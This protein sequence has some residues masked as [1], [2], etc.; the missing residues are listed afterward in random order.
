MYQGCQ[1]PLT[2][3]CPAHGEF[4]QRPDRHLAGRGCPTC[5]RLKQ[6]AT[7]NGLSLEVLLQAQR[8]GLRYCRNHGFQGLDKFYSTVVRNGRV[9]YHCL[10][11][12]RGSRRKNRLKV[13]RWANEYTQR[14]RLEVLKHYSPELECAICGEGH[15]EFLA[16]DHIHGGGQ[17]K[18]VV[19]GLTGGGS[20][21][22]SI[23]KAG[24]PSG[25]RVLCHNC[26][27]KHGCRDFYWRGGNPKPAEKLSTN[28]LTQ[29]VRR[30]NARHPERAREMALTSR[31]K[32][33][34][35][36]IGHY[37]GVCACCGEDDL[38]VLSI[39]HVNGGGAR[40][41]RELKAKGEVFGY[42]WLKKNG[43][44]LGFRVLCLNCNL[45][46]GLYGRCPHEAV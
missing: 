2:I 7:R 27:H 16:L 17:G 23:R 43:F 42:H 38:D 28:P 14:I 8:D 26:N 30:F 34:A 39:D 12:S 10:E 25:Y 4:K 20:Y 6:W 46:R 37:G 32:R 15:L 45:A 29:A 19:A 31:R 24:F 36:V 5:G 21:W 9:W 1:V 13:N 22:L 41:R 35:E 40:H 3:V 18:R 11:C 44:P 33:K